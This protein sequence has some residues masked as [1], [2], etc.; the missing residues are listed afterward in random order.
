MTTPHTNQD[1]LNF[2][3]TGTGEKGVWNIPFTLLFGL[4]IMFFFGLF[5]ALGLFWGAQMM[6]TLGDVVESLRSG[7]SSFMAGLSSHA[8]YL[9]PA[10]ILGGV[11]GSLAICLFIYL[12]K[13]HDFN[14]YL[15]LR[16]PSGIDLLKWVGIFIV[17][18]F[19]AEFLTRFIDDFES[20]F[21]DRIMET[22]TKPYMLILG[23]GVIAPIFEELL[24]RGFFY[25]GLAESKLGSHIAIIITSILFAIIH[26]Q[27]N[28]AIILM[29]IPMALILGYS[30]YYTKSIWTPIVL[31]VLNNTISTVAGL[32]AAGTLG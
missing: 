8:E 11:G 17:F 32:Y 15:A 10:A 19:L 18:I 27:Y 7:D 2:Y 24:F 14:D 22:S 13:N 16:M 25:K 12:K 30:R 29:I 28:L 4:V 23:V 3:F 21:M 1:D 5:Q 20:P 6:G 31:H 26:M 9:W